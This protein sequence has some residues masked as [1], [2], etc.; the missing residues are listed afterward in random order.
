MESSHGDRRK[1]DLNEHRVVMTD[2]NIGTTRIQYKTNDWLV[3]ADCHVS[4]LI[5]LLLHLGLKNTPIYILSPHEN[6]AI[7]LLKYENYSLFIF[8]SSVFGDTS[9]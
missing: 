2:V 3:I 4:N 8:S 1:K 5:Y 6:Y 7:H 9:V